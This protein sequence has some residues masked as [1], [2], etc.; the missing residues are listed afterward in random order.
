[1]EKKMFQED[2]N[3]NNDNDIA[4]SVASSLLV[5]DRYKL[6]RFVQEVSQLV[7]AEKNIRTTTVLFTT[8]YFSVKEERKIVLRTDRRTDKTV[9]SEQTNGRADRRTDGRPWQ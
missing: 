8:T 2:K 3:D 7:L 5:Y 6:L 4:R 9:K 1:M